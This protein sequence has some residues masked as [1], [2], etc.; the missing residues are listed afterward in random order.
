MAWVGH[1][2]GG[3]L[4]FES[5]LFQAGLL[6]IQRKAARERMF[7]PGWTPRKGAAGPRGTVLAPH[8]AFPAGLRPPAFPP[9]APGSQ[10]RGSPLGAVWPCLT[11]VP[12]C[13]C[14]ISLLP[15]DIC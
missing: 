5:G 4:W 3:S 1:V 8:T 7:S 12:I 10:L 2:C 15:F 14:L 11:G 13:V 9:A 6:R